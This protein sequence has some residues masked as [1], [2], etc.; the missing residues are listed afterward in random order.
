MSKISEVIKKLEERKSQFGDIDVLYYDMDWQCYYDLDADDVDFVV[1]N[2]RKT[3]DF[4]LT[5][6]GISPYDRP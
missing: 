2:F 4:Q 6:N 1:G 3:S 5:I